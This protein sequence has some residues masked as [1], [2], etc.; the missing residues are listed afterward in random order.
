MSHVKHLDHLN[1][2][3]KNL[4]ESIDYYQNLFGFSVVESG[5]QTSGPWAI[6]KAGDA[7]LCLYEDR[8]TWNA[9]AQ[10]LKHFALRITNEEHFLKQVRALDIAFSYEQQNWKH[11]TSWYVYD[12]S[13]Y[14]IEVVVWND[15]VIRFEERVAT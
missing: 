13:G 4:K 7:M 11:S 1:M 10:G 2:S 8:D 15:D 14:E 12:P 9:E 5:T 3:V 6:I